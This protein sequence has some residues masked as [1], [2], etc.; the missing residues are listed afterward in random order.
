[1][2]EQIIKWERQ[3]GEYSPIITNG[4]MME[5]KPKD[6]I[7]KRERETEYQIQKSPDRKVKNMGAF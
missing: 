3:Q 1:M 7:K 2:I 4:R 6:I 5:F